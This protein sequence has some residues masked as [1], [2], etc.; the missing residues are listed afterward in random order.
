MINRA[1]VYDALDEA[2]NKGTEDLWGPVN[3]PRDFPTW[4]LYMKEYLNDAET[5]WLESN[6]TESTEAKECLTKAVAVGMLCLDMMN[7]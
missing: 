7:Y 2:L 1:K 5:A 4:L 3:A 6:Y